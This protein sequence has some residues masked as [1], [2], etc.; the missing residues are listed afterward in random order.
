MQ[1]GKVIDLFGSIVTVG[2]VTVIIT[3]TQ[4]AG[5]IK[6]WGDAFSGSLK[7]AMGH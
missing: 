6:A 2:M 5:I 4:T 7:A 3:S 1:L